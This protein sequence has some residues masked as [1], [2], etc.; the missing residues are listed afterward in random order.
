LA[1]AEP[2]TLGRLADTLGMERRRVIEVALKRAVHNHW[3]YR[4]GER[5][6]TLALM[7]ESVEQ[8]EP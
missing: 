4:E 6:L 7:D 8:T 5:Y 2:I 3:A 1:A